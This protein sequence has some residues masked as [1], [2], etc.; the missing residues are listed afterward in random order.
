MNTRQSI[1]KAGKQMRWLLW[2]VV[3]LALL[4]VLGVPTLFH[5]DISPFKNNTWAALGYTLL[6]SQS[7]AQSGAYLALS[8][9]QTVV[10]GLLFLALSVLIAA[11]VWLVDRL[12]KQFSEGVVFKE[13][14][15]RYLYMMGWVLMGL[16]VLSAIADTFIEYVLVAQSKIPLSAVEASEWGDAEDWYVTFISFDFSLLLAGLFAVSVAHVMRL[17]T[18]LQDDV[19]STI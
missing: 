12:F 1:I 7:S 4:C 8:T 17:G 16:F 5:L 14:S 9:G 6:D 11:L 15:S 19:D 13:G 10:T 18:Q 3:I 2:G